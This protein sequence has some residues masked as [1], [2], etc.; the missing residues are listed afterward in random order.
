[1][2]DDSVSWTGSRT[3]LAVLVLSAGHASRL[4]PWSGEHPK[5]LLPTCEGTLLERLLGPMARRRPS[6]HLACRVPARSTADDVIAEVHAVTPQADVFFVDGDPW[7]PIYARAR[8]LNAH[9]VLVILNG[10]LVLDREWHSLIARAIDRRTGITLCADGA[11]SAGREVWAQPDLDGRYSPSPTALTQRAIGVSV[12][13]PGSLDSLDPCMALGADPWFNRILPELSRHVPVRLE[14]STAPWSDVGSWR[15]LLSMEQEL[16]VGT[17]TGS[18]LAGSVDHRATVRN[19]LVMAGASVEAGAAVEDSVVLPGV[20]VA[21]GQRIR[22][23]LISAHEVRPLEFDA[24][25][26]HA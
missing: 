9:D 18:C 20:T 14:T 4:A 3:G 23:S 2:S 24:V 26:T 17:S 7:V 10:D 8:R 16:H 6:V 15:G 22:G 19:S 21:S 5:T 12:L 13:A 11:G 25:G 1:M